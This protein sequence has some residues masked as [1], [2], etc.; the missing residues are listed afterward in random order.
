MKKTI[1]TAVLVSGLAGLAHA[2]EST[3]ISFEDLDVNK[4]DA[5][6]IAETGN[7]PEIS[8]QWST[9]DVDGDGQLSKDEFAGYAAPAPAAGNQ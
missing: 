4:N 2:E 3:A 9:L 7:L 5:L 1:F 6:S 8:A